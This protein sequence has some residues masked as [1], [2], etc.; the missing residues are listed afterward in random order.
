MSSL[1]NLTLKKA[2]SLLKNKE[3]EPKE[4]LSHFLKK[5]KEDK[6]ETN[7]INAVVYF[8]EEKA[9]KEISNIS[10]NSPL[11]GAPLLIK[12]NMN[13]GNEPLQCAS[14]ILAGYISPYTGQ[15]CSQLQS[16][17]A[18]LFGRCNMDEFAM[19]S[20]TETS[21]FGITR[22]PINK[23]YIP[24]GSSGG[25]AAA[26]AA[27]WC[28]A[29]LGSD[30]GGS[31]R[32]P[33]A[34]C[35]VVGLKP[36]YGRVSR[37]GLVA[38]AS[39]LDQIG[40]LTKT[41]ED[42]AIVLQAI[43]GYDPKETTSINTPV[44]NYTQ[45]IDS[46]LKGKKIGFPKEFF[47]KDLDSEI[48]KSLL[49]AKD[50]FQKQNCEIIEISLENTFKY[51]MSCYYITNTAEASA[52]LS[53]FD[54]IRYGH[55]SEKVENLNEVYLHSRGEG[56]GAEVK[57]RILLGTY[58]L[59][60]GFYDAYYNKAQ[61]VRKLIK[62]EVDNVLKECD[63]IFTP[64]MPEKVFRLGE[65]TNDPIKMYLSDLFTTFS[66]LSGHPAISIPCGQDS[67]GLPISFQLVANSFQ[68]KDLFHFGN[69]YEKGN[70]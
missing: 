23:E 21:V 32:Q 22:N 68:E 42:S 9:L 49:I 13:I 60:S 53:R 36:T 44:P 67:N 66:N 58:V 65:K 61:K 70:K 35:G 56:F 69:V 1:N 26:V 5:I 11:A 33:A 3:I 16:N 47:N 45:D 20:S 29:S 25:S 34:C 52:N 15:A 14:K 54:G 46:S 18:I 37:Y 27:D 38:F 50:F 43:A 51:A 2:I 12:D 64:T 7:S 41:V 10:L 28:L 40:P 30:T 62:N 55:R 17:G 19:G 31:I 63:V 4:L 8:D 57:R 24:G 6:K 48:L 59:S 39:S